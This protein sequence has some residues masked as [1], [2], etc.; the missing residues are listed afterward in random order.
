[1]LTTTAP[2]ERSLLGLTAHGFHRVVWHEWGDVANPD[3]VVCVH[4]LT[5]S[6][7]DFDV[8][9]DALASTHRVLAVDTV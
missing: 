4:G 3:V 2:R 1:M 9:G 7:R 8:L 5:R 6:G